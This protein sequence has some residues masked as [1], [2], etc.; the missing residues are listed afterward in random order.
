MSR[1]R[2]ISYKLVAKFPPVKRDLAVV[3]D[4]EVPVAQIEK[5]IRAKGKNLEKLELFDVYEGK[6]I[7]EGKKSVAFSLT[8]RAPDRTLSDEE[9]NK[10][11]A[12]II[13]ELSKIGAN[14][15]A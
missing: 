8:F 2:R 9:V 7:P 5:V 4:R 13:N 12:D 11:L 14:L 6:G 1:E 15:R 10:V 3:V